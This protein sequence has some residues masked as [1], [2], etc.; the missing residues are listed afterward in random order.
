MRVRGNGGKITYGKRKKRSLDNFLCRPGLNCKSRSVLGKSI[1][2]SSSLYQY[3][4]R[5]KTSLQVWQ[6]FARTWIALA[7]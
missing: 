7:N 3:S 5:L 4:A 1:C 2:K 6:V